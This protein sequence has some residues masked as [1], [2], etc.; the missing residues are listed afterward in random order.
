MNAVGYNQYNFHYT[1]LCQEFRERKESIS[2]NF[3]GIIIQADL[4]QMQEKVASIT[5][6]QNLVSILLVKT[7]AKNPMC[8]KGYK[9]FLQYK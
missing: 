9:K 7:K 2:E 1:C 5:I 3:R 8:N 6:E 4:C